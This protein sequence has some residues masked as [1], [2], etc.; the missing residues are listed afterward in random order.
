MFLRDELINLSYITL[1][2]RSRKALGFH[3]GSD[4]RGNRVIKGI[5]QLSMPLHSSL[6]RH[7]NYCRQV[8][9]GGFLLTYRQPVGSMIRASLS[10]T[11]GD[12]VEG[13]LVARNINFKPPLLSTTVIHGVQVACIYQQLDYAPLRCSYRCYCTFLKPHHTMYRKKT[14]CCGPLSLNVPGTIPTNFVGID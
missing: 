3:P 5:P 8:N 7:G 9:R 10:K 1:I 12:R 6:P 2:P 4:V 14:M 13:F 11:S